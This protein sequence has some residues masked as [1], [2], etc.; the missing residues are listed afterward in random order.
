MFFVLLYFYFVFLRFIFIFIFFIRNVMG[1]SRGLH[2]G[3]QAG[4]S[5]LHQG[6][7]CGCPKETGALCCWDVCVCCQEV[8]D[9]GMRIHC[10]QHVP[11][12]LDPATVGAGPR[13]A[14]C[15]VGDECCGA[16]DVWSRCLSVVLP[17]S[18]P[19]Y[20]KPSH[21]C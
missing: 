4:P 14:S 20:V 17:P 8:C 16:T 13:G 10:C 3:N 19:L 18:H 9:A 21:S 6:M 7:V 12:G 5:L 1:T 2:E 11:A 15:T